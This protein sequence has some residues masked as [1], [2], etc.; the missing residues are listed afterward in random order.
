MKTGKT[1]SHA[2][3]LL[4]TRWPRPIIIGATL[5]LG[6]WAPTQ[7]RAQTSVNT[8]LTASVSGGQVQLRL[9]GQA[10]QTYLVQVSSDLKN[11]T[12]VAR[13]QTAGD[14][15]MTVTD[16][17]ATRVQGRYYR[18]VLLGFPT[19]NASASLYRP[20]RIL[21]KPKAGV[22]L[23]GLNLT[24]GVNMLQEFPAIGHLQVLQVPPGKTADLLIASFQASG[25]VQYAEHDYIVHALV[26]PNDFYYNDDDTLWGLHNDGSNG[27]LT[28]A[29]IHAPEAW[30]IQNTAS[31]VTV[32]VI[33]TG[34]RY[35]HEDLAS[36][37]WVNPNDGSHGLNTVTNGNAA[38][39]PND[40]YGHG[41]H[42]AGILGAVGDNFV[43]VVGV[44]WSVPIMACC[45]LDSTGNGTISDAIACM[46]YARTNGAE[47]VN[48][49]WGTTN[50]D[51]QAL[52]DA[53]DN[54]RQA[55]IIFV[56]AAGNSSYDNDMTPIYPASYNLDNIIAVAAT[57]RSDQ[58]ASFSD[59]GPT[60]VALGAP[61]VDIESCW[62][63][64]DHD[65]ES[66]SGTSMAAA[67][68]S[69]A[70]AI[71]RAHF[72]NED[73]H[74]I[75]SQILTNVDQVP[76]LQ[77]Q[78][79]SGGRLNLYRALTSGSPAHPP[80]AANFTAS[81]T[82]GQ[83]PLAVQFTD[84]STGSPTAWDWNFGDGSTDSTTENPSHIYTNA[85]TFTVTLTVTGSGG[86]TSSASGT[87]T[88]TNTSPP[89][90][91]PLAA[92]FTA[93]PTN[94]QAPLTVQFTDTSIGSPTAWD[95]NFGDGSTDGTT[96]NPSHI[97]TNAGTFTVT[98]TVTGS[99]GATSSTSG[100]I[101][102]T[103][104]S[105]P[106]PPPL[107]ANFTASPTN[108]QAPL[109]VQFTDMSTGSPT[110]WDWNFGDG[111]TDSTTGNP[112]HTFTSAGNFTVT[113]TVSGSAGQTSS[114][115]QSITV[116]NPPAAVTAQ[117]SAN[118]ASGQAPLAVQ[119]TDQSTGPVTAWKWNFGD[120]STSS[121]QN[122][123][124]TYSSAGSFTAMLTVSGSAGQTSSGSQSITVTNPPAAVTAQFSANP[125]SGQAPL[126]VQFTDQSTGPVTAWKWSFGDGSTSSAQNPSHTYS[127]AGSFTAM[128]T[129]SGSS[130]QISSASQTITV[131]NAPPPPIVVTVVT[132]QSLA[133]TLTPGAFTLT[134]TG[135]T[136]SPLTINYGLGG[137]AVNGV[138]YESLSGSAVIPAGSSS[139]TVLV[140][141]IGLLDLLR[142]VVLTV[143]PGQAYAVGSPGSATVT[144]VVS[145]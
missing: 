64:S 81:P 43:G 70:C 60:N 88:A 6:L 67:Y 91:P 116:T 3:D 25:Q 94:G 54:L 112:S 76:S 38:N 83:A 22:N 71:L 101:T 87:I 134:R 63:G 78:C 132:S 11:W 97:Y 92:S 65:Y 2:T 82:N 86:A 103:N 68:V 133:T 48:A 14:G 20:D 69:G 37:M 118:P 47:I 119:F 130:Q 35:T 23:G 12:T 16:T 45:F 17:W 96:E 19:G 26:T 115:S 33:D 129:V 49:S 24:L 121:A 4:R 10:N 90:P 140:E 145:F 34:V 100:T 110:A 123:S 124:H 74:Q 62:N 114:G 107:A 13:G 77:G 41:S 95:W 85:G 109:A 21:V 138:N 106:P 1:L 105:P 143:S 125:T 66:Q 135:S 141:P 144:I 111:S 46:D 131:T 57:T 28:N 128:L 5:L 15:S 36:N 32:A 98:L 120:G 93:S 72:P 80:L 84:T 102:A 61:G 42:V 89:P 8:K 27:G 142:T 79:R 126:A 58:L 52:Y 56:A 31:N 59:Y 55:G 108:G 117:F 51:S 139:V 104:A 75:I 30:D 18:S 40:D 50:F 7:V 39:D 53:I 99:G 73:Y 9:Q 122:P 127:S 29:D 113:L 137:T 44:A 136:S